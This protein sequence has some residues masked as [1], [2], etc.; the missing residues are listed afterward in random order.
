M[1]QGPQIRDIHLPDSISWWPPA[2][3]WWVL[4]AIVLL[5]ALLLTWWIRKKQKAYNNS[6]PKALYVLDKI[7]NN[8]NLSDSDIIRQLSSLLRRVAMSVHGRRQ[9]AGLTG[10][11]WLGFLDRQMITK[12]NDKQAT[13]FRQGIG[14]VFREQP[15]SKKTQYEREQLIQLVHRWISAQEAKTPTIAPQKDNLKKIF[16]RGKSNV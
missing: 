13:I 5:L 9:V 1:K 8:K 4:L 7:K 6:I 15:Y 14:Q 2:P 11:D 3:G 12:K 10:N 16:T